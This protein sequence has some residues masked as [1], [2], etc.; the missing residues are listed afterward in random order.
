MAF[1]SYCEQKINASLISPGIDFPAYCQYYIL[2]MSLVDRITLFLHRTHAHPILGRTIVEDCTQS[3]EQCMLFWNAVYTNPINREYLAISDKI[4]EEH[5][6][7]TPT[8]PKCDCILQK[9]PTHDIPYSTQPFYCWAPACKQLDMYIPSTTRYYIS[10]C[11]G[12]I[13]SVKINSINSTVDISI[14]NNI[15]ATKTDS[16]VLEETNRPVELLI[17]PIPIPSFG[18]TSYII[19]M[20]VILAMCFLVLLGIRLKRHNRLVLD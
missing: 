15:T 4:L 3:P 13:E 1:Q 9:R 12:L 19:Y 10:K 17:D 18:Y 7:S 6:I 14:E 8:D 20:V 11:T 16:N 5:C 2:G